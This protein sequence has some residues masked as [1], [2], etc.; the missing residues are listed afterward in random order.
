[1]P[2][3]GT[4]AHPIWAVDALGR[5]ANAVAGPFPNMLAGLC[6]FGRSRVRNQRTGAREFRE[7]FKTRP[8]QARLVEKTGSTWPTSIAPRPTAWTVL[9][10]RVH[11]P[12]TDATDK[13]RSRVAHLEEL[14]LDELEALIRAVATGAATMAPIATCPRPRRTSTPAG[15]QTAPR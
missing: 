15:D 2:L 8:R 10:M 4:R 6:A 7:P 12:A 1:M 13:L 5:M 14:S 11:T 3:A 9:T